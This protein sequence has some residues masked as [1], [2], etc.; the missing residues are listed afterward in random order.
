MD[1]KLKK[2]PKTAKFKVIDTIQV[3]HPYCVGVRLIAHASKH[4]YGLLDDSAIESAERNG[5]P[6]ETCDTLNKKTGQTILSHKE[7]GHAI[8]VAVLNKRPLQEVWKDGLQAYLLSIKSMIEAD[9]YVGVAF[10]QL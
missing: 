6:C 4:N 2:Y 7:H 8:L 9:G 1:E 10:K 5:I 3:P